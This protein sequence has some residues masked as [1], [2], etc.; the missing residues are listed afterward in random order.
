MTD[1]TLRRNELCIVGL[2][3][4]NYVLNS[5]RSAFIAYGFRTSKMEVTILRSILKE[6]EMEAVEAGDALDPGKMAFCTK[7][8]SKIIT[9]Q[10]CIILL[11]HDG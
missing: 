6:Y 7:I 1:L 10:F 4:C 8:C 3:A 11:N 5:T 2:P 9:A